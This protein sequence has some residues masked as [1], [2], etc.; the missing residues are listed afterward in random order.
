LPDSIRGGGG[1]GWTDE[2]VEIV[3]VLPKS[4]LTDDAQLK[5]FEREARTAASLH[6]TNIV[7]VFGVGEDQGFHY[8]VM[9]RIEGRGLD[10]LLSA[11]SN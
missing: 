9:Q 7:P 5:R 4:L 2:N 8:Y 1:L 11:S 3:K 10:R 6:H